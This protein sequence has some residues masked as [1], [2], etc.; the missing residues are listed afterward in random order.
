MKRRNSNDPHRRSLKQRTAQTLEASADGL[1][2][3]KRVLR[4][5]PVN[6]GEAPWVVKIYRTTKEGVSG[7][8]GTV[9]SK[10]WILTAA[11]C[12]QKPGETDYM[13]KLQVGVF[14]DLA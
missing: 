13:F 4:G 2:L 9:I 12:C 14:G 11:H 8:T 10:D 7:C 6:T 1:R 5:Q 3:A